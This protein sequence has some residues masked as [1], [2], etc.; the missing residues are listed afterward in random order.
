MSRMMQINIGTA[1]WDGTRL[2]TVEIMQVLAEVLRR[3]FQVRW[4]GPDRRLRESEGT[5]VVLTSYKEGEY[6]HEGGQI[7]AGLRQS[8]VAMYVE[9]YARS[10]SFGR[11]IGP[12][13]LPVT[14][15]GVPFDLGRFKFY[16]DV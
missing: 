7:A 6:S 16:K 9:A 13:G 1:T 11:L 3:P 10:G 12:L 8:A 4:A 2:G 15:N 14:Y 5:A